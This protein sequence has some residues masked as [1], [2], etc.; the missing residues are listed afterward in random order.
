MTEVSEEI[1]EKA[2]RLLTEGRL[3]VVKRGVLDGGDAINAVCVGD[4]G[5]YQ[6]RRRAGAAFCSCPSPRLCAHLFAL[7]LVVD[8]APVPETAA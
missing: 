7:S 4:H 5:E 8:P 2:H 6:I 1:L 3:T